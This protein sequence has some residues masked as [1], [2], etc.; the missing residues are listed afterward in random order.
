M[1]PKGALVLVASQY[2]QERKKNPNS[3]NSLIVHLELLDLQLGLEKHHLLSCLLSTRLDQSEQTLMKRMR[4]LPAI[5]YL[6]IIKQSWKQ[7]EK[8]TASYSERLTQVRAKQTAPA[9]LSDLWF[10]LCSCQP[11]SAL[12]PSLLFLLSSM[13]MIPGTILAK[14]PNPKTKPVP[15]SAATPLHLHCTSLHLYSHSLLPTSLPA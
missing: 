3:L 6:K 9:P 5:S 14:N 12:L 13:G 1:A 4:K 11:T 2:Q 7:N 15:V 10:F 8:Q